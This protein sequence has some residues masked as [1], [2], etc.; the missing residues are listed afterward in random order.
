MGDALTAAA[1]LGGLGGLCGGLLGVAYR[2]LRVPENPRLGRVES[3][4]PGTN[5]GACGEPGCHAFAEALLAGTRAPSRCTV[6]SPQGIAN[7]ATFLGVEAGEQDKR[8]AR[9]HCAGGRGQATQIAAYEGFESCRG[10]VV[11]SGGGKGCA[12]GCLGL[13]DCE[14]SCTFD[15]IGMNPQGL[16][17]VDI[18]RCTACGDCVVACPRD[19]FEILPVRQPLLVQCRIP[20]AG[21]Q[22]VAL[23]TVACDACG[24]CAADAPSLVRMDGNLPVVDYEARVEVGPLATA[25]CPTGAIAWVPEGQFEVGSPTERTR[26]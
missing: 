7:I 21:E 14:R 17:V 3:M 22:A 4:L 16:P 19:L 1:I 26:P 5:C 15:A 20:L 13:A 8:V 18:E 9:L 6:S 11:V 10:A 23:C 24:R 2:Y 25:R 12:W